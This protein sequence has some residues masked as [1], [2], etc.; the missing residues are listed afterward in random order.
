VVSSQERDFK[1]YDHSTPK[2]AT[3]SDAQQSFSREIAR[4]ASEIDLSKGNKE[5]LK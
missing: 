5:D 3:E 2:T 4:E 1:K